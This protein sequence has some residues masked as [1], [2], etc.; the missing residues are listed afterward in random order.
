[1]ARLGF[2]VEHFFAI[3]I[4]TC[5]LGLWL[6]LQ[7]FSERAIQYFELA[8]KIDKYVLVA[9]QIFFAVS[10]LVPVA[11]YTYVDLRVMLIRALHKLRRETRD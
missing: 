10:T 4:D 1:M 6:L 7:W 3:V 9:F 2:F 11:I 8:D 5:F